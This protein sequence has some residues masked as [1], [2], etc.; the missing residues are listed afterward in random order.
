MFDAA[1]FT[2]CQQ[3]SMVLSQG[4]LQNRLRQEHPLWIKLCTGARWLP[5]VEQS[6]F[7]RCAGLL[8][9]WPAAKTMK[10]INYQA[11]GRAKGLWPLGT[12]RAIPTV[13]SDLCSYLY[14]KSIRICLLVCVFKQATNNAVTVPI[15]CN[16]DSWAATNRHDTRKKSPS[17]DTKYTK[18]TNTS[19][20][21]GSG[22]V[23]RTWVLWELDWSSS[24]SSIKQ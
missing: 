4:S 11:W 21:L 8:I 13:A 2:L 24:H 20:N 9:C 1:A 18:Y 19:A 23:M 16:T 14:I 5:D 7:W 17:A 6:S 22:L 3:E 10:K 15:S 12:S